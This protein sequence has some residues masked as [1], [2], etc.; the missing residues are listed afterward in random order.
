MSEVGRI[1]DGLPLDKM[2]ADWAQRMKEVAQPT[3]DDLL[4][5]LFVQLDEIRREL[6]TAHVRGH[7]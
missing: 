1:L 3:N 6:Q 2:L 7:A 5:L 4:V